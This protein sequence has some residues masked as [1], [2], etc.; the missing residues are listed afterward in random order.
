MN[1]KNPDLE[2]FWESETL[3]EFRTILRTTA[4]W[5]AIPLFSV[6]W[7]ADVLY[8]PELKWPFLAI[9]TLV[10]PICFLVTFAVEKAQTLKNAQRIAA[11]YAFS[12]A[13]GINLMILLLSDP[14]TGY[15]AGLNL[16]AIGCLSF[17]PFNRRFYLLTALGIYLPYF[18]IVGV[19]I[20]FGADWHIVLVNSFFITSSICMCFLIRFFHESLRRKEVQAR[21][22]LKLEIENRDQLIKVKTE[23]AVKLNALSS[24]FSPQLV[25]SIRSGKLHFD[26][27][28]KRAPI[29]A[30]FIDI[31]NSTERVTR[32]DKDKV[33]RT[34]S[35]FLDDS[36]RILLKYDITIDKFLG[37]GLL[38]FCNA[39]LP[40]SDYTSRVVSAAIEVREKIALEREFFE[41]NWQ[42]ELQIRIG[43]AKGFANVGFYGSQKYFKSYTAI[44]PVMNLAA[45]L[46]TAA[47]PG[48][49]ITDYDVFD[50]IKQDF[51]TQFLGRQSLKGFEQDV[52][53]VYEIKGGRK[54]KA[55]NPGL[56]ECPDCNS[57]L[58]LETN[59]KGQFVFMCKSCDLVIEN[60]AP[61]VRPPSIAS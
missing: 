39:P 7:M 53:H 20:L 35:R 16:V 17:I 27:G 45:R 59:S 22:Q 49:I 31:V 28:S 50:E 29:C 47:E 1:L 46:C 3:E 26:Q 52:T 37:D 9:R 25:E 5:M 56:S 18:T 8:A 30:I 42:T 48:Q 13:L 57:M 15:Y 40:R 11:F 24:Q 54:F 12:L 10:V 2:K 32:L 14:G 6:F 41:R 34:L 44:G 19:K 58:S 36:I 61:L 4:H 21:H 33:E 60:V 51:E 23:E 43:I 55:L 38:G